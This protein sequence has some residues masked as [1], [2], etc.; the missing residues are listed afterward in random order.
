MAR[1]GGNTACVVIESEETTPIVLD[2]GTGLRFYGLEHGDQPFEGT[3][4]LTHLHWDHVQGL[5][6][7]TPF[8]NPASQTTVYGPP[9]QDMDFATAVSG[10][11]RPPYFPISVDDLPSTFSLVDIAAETIDV[12]GARITAAPVPHSGMTN[13][14]RVEINGVSIAYLP[15]HQEPEDGTSIADSVLELVDGADVLIHDAQFTDELLAQRSNWGHCTP[16]YA[17]N[18]AEAAGVDTLVLF[19]HDPLHDDDDLDGLLDQVA[20]LATKTRVLSATE[21]LQISL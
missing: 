18:V 20:G 6:F 1:Y 7:F 5:P 12:G 14:Y 16:R 11:L 3:V 15:D 4:L 2:G 21:G 19:H 10:F 17:L 9:E 8:L 13:G